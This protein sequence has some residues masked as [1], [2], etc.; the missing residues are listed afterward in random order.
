MPNSFTL[1]TPSTATHPWPQAMTIIHAFTSD[2]AFIELL[3]ENH[4]DTHDVTSIDYANALSLYS[5]NYIHDKSINDT[6]FAQVALLANA[7]YFLHIQKEMA[8]FDHEKEHRWLSDDEIRYLKGFKPYMAWFN[9]HI[10]DYMYAHP[11]E[12]MSDMNYSLAEISSSAFPGERDI[13]ENE[14]MQAMRGARTESITRQ[15]LDRTSLQYDS[16]TPEDD[17]RGGDLMLIRNGQRV[18]VDIKSSISSIAR[19]RGGY[20]QIDRQ[21]ISF[22]ISHK[23]GTNKSDDVIELFPGF[24]RYDLGDSFSLNVPESDVQQHADYVAEQLHLAL[25]QHGI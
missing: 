19:L 8:K 22:G 15:L 21:H 18:K 14:L 9:Q 3:D 10:S 23:H 25:D 20:E 13:I 16:G 1:P 24:D 17:L 12:S 5:E 4:I 11:T 6:T 2:V 7:P